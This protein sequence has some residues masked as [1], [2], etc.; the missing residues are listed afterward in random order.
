[1]IPENCKR[2]K[3]HLAKRGYKSRRKDI[4]RSNFSRISVYPS[5]KEYL[6]KEERKG[7]K[8]GDVVKVKI[9][10]LDES[11]KGIA[12]Y[13]GTKVLVEDVTPGTEVLCKIVRVVDGKAF[14][15]AL[16]G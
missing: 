4:Y 13:K 1:M 6:N 11:G 8:E 5:F 10:G 3:I 14:A 12:Y 7:V 2:R 9:V 15:K 16:K